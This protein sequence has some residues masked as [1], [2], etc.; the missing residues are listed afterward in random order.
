M[1]ESMTT[2]GSGGR[3]ALG[4]M[5]IAGLLIATPLGAIL[6]ML[7]LLFM[8]LGLFFFILFGLLIGAVMYRTGHSA[9]PLARS[10]LVFVGTVVSMY[11]WFFGL[12]LEAYSQPRKISEKVLQE[13]PKIPLDMTRAEALASVGHQVRDYFREHYGSAGIVGYSRWILSG[14]SIDMRVTPKTKVITSTTPQSWWGYPV[15]VLLSLGLMMM[16]IFSQILPLQEREDP[17]DVTWTDPSAEATVPAS[18]ASEDADD[19]EAHSLRIAIAAKTR[20]N[21][22]TIRIPE[23]IASAQEA[24]TDESS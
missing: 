20:T 18:G 13:T 12:Y 19:S 7:G 14:E 10:G 16:G 24:S 9:R 17:P 4:R 22:R 8:F 1:N 5:T 2:P 3:S 6:S 15:R 21:G 11:A 23:D